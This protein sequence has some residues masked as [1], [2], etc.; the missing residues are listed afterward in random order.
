MNVLDECRPSNQ[1]R[2]WSMQRENPAVAAHVTPSALTPAAR[3]RRALSYMCLGF[4]RI[5][6]RDGAG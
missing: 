6:G 5:A 4:W 2:F 3:M 1:G